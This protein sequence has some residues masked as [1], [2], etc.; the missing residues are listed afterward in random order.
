MRKQENLAERAELSLIAADARFL[1]DFVFGSRYERIRDVAILALMP[2]ISAFTFESSEY[3]KRK[4]PA[5]VRA[6]EPHGGLLRASRLCLKLL[7]DNRKS[8][9][10]VLDNA[11]ELAAISSGWMMEDHR[12]LL[13]PLKR[14]IQPDLGIYF[15]QDEA[16]CTTHVAFLNL[17]LS[18][19]A[20][21]ASALSFANLGPYLRD[22]SEDFGRYVALLLR[23]LGMSTEASESA[24]GVPLSSIGFRDL[25]SKRLYKEMARRAAPNRV[26][27]CLLLTATLSQVNTARLLVP[28]IAEHN[29]VA[30]FKIR[31]V[32]LFHAASSLQKLMDQDQ[33]GPLL[34]PDA[35]RQIDAALRPDPVQNILGNRFLRN[36]LVHY[37]VHKSAVSQLS[38]ELPLFGL[39][40]ALAKGRSLST[41]AND[42]ELGLDHISEIL[43]DLLPEWLTPQA[44]L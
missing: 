29:E 6:L 38:A 33:D 37:G 18:K 11:S 24:R 16:F 3:F 44:T 14:L 13:G 26:P 19:E 35:A 1:R 21:A 40:D 17:G 5:M 20:L 28:S 23:K 15:A 25:K 10:E 7:D 30:A 34:H 8:F 41:V 27:V 32:S 42:V 36:N 9:D 12:R 39:V 31:F 43:G 22:T 4:D 2:F